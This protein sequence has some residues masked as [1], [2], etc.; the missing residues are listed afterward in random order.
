[1]TNLKAQRKMASSILK[2]GVNR[3]HIDPEHHKINDV[4]LALTR[5]DIEKLISSGVISKRKVIGTSRRNARKNH[6]KRQRGQ[7][8]GLGS[9]KGSLNARSN[10]KTVWINKIRAQRKYLKKLRDE[11]YITPN[12]YR[13]LYL[14]AKGNLFRSVRYLSSVISERGLA[15]KKIPPYNR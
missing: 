10:Q 9:R 6:P 2:V 8:K 5:A 3:V 4:A 12:T 15:E 13:T 11:G 14:Q 7:R 1:M